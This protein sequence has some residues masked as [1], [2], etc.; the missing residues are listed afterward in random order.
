[1]KKIWERNVFTWPAPEIDFL[2]R[3]DCSP[4]IHL[5]NVT[6]ENTPDNWGILLARIGRTS[7]ALS[8]S[9]RI[10]VS[11]C[12]QSIG[13]DHVSF[14][15]DRRKF[16]EPAGQEVDPFTWIKVSFRIPR[17]QGFCDAAL[18][19]LEDFLK[20]IGVDPLP[21]SDL[22]GFIR[23]RTTM[24]RDSEKGWITFD[25]SLRLA[26]GLPPSGLGAIRRITCRDGFDDWLSRPCPRKGTQGVLFWIKKDPTKR[27]RGCEWWG[28]WPAN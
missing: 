16:H 11:T 26:K 3:V 15:P 10:L 23:T 18:D 6:I 27:N 22:S 8:R 7:S 28:V 25:D 19:F 5:N 14:G 2:T 1:M 13:A 21:L 9:T 17:R 12:A 20:T 24:C 4:I